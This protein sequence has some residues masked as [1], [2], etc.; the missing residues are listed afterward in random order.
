MSIS[1]SSGRRIRWVL[2]ALALASAAPVAAQYPGGAIV[3]PLPGAGDPAEK[4]AAAL[5]TLAV[6]PR[7]LPA[8]IE[9]G[10]DALTLG[11]PNAAVGFFGRANELSPRDGRVKAGLGAALVQLEKPVDA[12]RYFREASALGVRDVDLAEDRGLAYDLIGDP[13]HAQ[14]DYRLVLA[15]HPDDDAVRRRLALS[16]G[17]AGDRAAAIATLDPLIRKRDIAAWRAQTFVLAMTGDAKG[18]ND[19]T[20]VMLPQQQ[21]MLQPFL[22]R[23]ATLSPGDKARAVHF[24]EMPAAGRS[25]SD[26]QLATIG[27]APTYAPAPAPIVTR[28]PPAP[29][30][31]A[32]SIVPSAMRAPISATPPRVA[33]AP[34]A[35]PL[36]TAPLVTLATHA[37]ATA[38]RERFVSPSGVPLR[39]IEHSAQ[40]VLALGMPR[41]E[42]VPLSAQA[43]ARAPAL[44]LAAAT[45]PATSGPSAP[46]GAGSPTA[47]PPILA[48]T[49]AAASPSG[50][51]AISSIGVSN[52][53]PPPPAVTNASAPPIT[54]SE[55]TVAE[56]AMPLGASGTGG[57][58]DMPHDIA[59]R[60][61]AQDQVSSSAR[62]PA[63][64]VQPRPSTPKTVPF[65]EPATANP[66][67]QT[68][69]RARAQSDPEV[70]A[71]DRP[72]RLGHMRGATASPTDDGD[73]AR[74]AIT[75]KRDRHR[76]QA[77]PTGKV[78]D[79]RS[80]RTDRHDDRSRAAPRDD[81]D[82]G[83]K[84]RSAADRKHDRSSED[85]AGT[86]TSSRS[87]PGK[88]KEKRDKPDRPLVAPKIYVQVAGGANRA[89]MDKAWAGVKAKAPDLMKGHTPATT[90]LHA[91]NRL[92]VG[93]FK[94]EDAA[95]AF[96]NKMAGKG[97]SGFTFKS[98]KGQKVEKID[99]AR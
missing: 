10:R 7:D 13:V 31:T 30:R 36:P 52:A 99:T 22:E 73:A 29:V 92:L 40:E 5:R 89:D 11:D 70:A 57:H 20:R 9:A 75:G 94:D 37:P 25:Y 72:V 6:S 62:P 14:G 39:R 28:P 74:P 97:L 60:R 86:E 79:A 23:L 87:K 46:L 68:A 3:Q 48:V 15:A 21:T 93:P 58:F 85:D 1:P 55:K 24:G 83:A 67:V 64:A 49:T 95:Q 45:A 80:D 16:Q 61:L 96:V 63:A 90:P 69:R 56:V 51:A 91:T 84:V 26:T 43:S 65:A 2:S 54:L 81:D 71:A 32:T 34:A 38:G 59:G 76:D 35:A 12:L 33:A 50:V 53:G 8:L 78:T 88:G 4:L 42:Y 41:Y 27:T 98:G 17:I 47:G 18:A 77:T 82:G 19:I 44:P 66:T